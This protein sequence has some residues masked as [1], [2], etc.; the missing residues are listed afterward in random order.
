MTLRLRIENVP[1]LASGDPVEQTLNEHGLVIGRAAHADWTLP[2][3][4]NH[5]SS[6]HAEIDFVDGAY[7]LT[8]RSTNGTFINGSAQRLTAPYP[9]KNGDLITIGQYEIRAEL[10]GARP[11]TAAPGMAG[12][13]MG[14]GLDWLSAAGSGSSAAIDTNRFGREPA[15]PLFQ[16]GADPLM[17]AFQMPGASGP[18]ADPFGIAAPAP[19]G[20]PFGFGG[21]PAAPPPPPAADPF[22]INAPAAPSPAANP[23]G[24]AP[25]A[26]PASSPFGVAPPASDPFG[27]GAPAPPPNTA[28]TTAPTTAPADDPWAKLHAFDTIDFGVAPTAPPPTPPPAAPAAAPATPAGVAATPRATADG[29]FDAF[30]AAAGLK[31]KDIGDLSPAAVLDAAG[32]LLR[33]TADG[34]IRLLDARTRIRHQFGVGANVTTFQRAGNNPLKWT[35]SP[36]QAL[37]QLVGEPDAGFLPGPQAVQGAF[38]DL[39]AHEVAMIAAM[40]DA[41]AAT[42]ERFSPDAIRAR[43][44]AKAGL[45][46]GSREAALWKAFEAEYKVLATESEAA[47]LDLFARNFKKAYERNIAKVDGAPR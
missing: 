28:P 37:R 40:Q 38:E 11:T 18:N 39:Q 25:A 17:H 1:S 34:L 8:D 27:I 9:L 35:R 23:F 30:L 44:N 2:D 15:K 31:P 43:V 14:G 32:R 10:S 21:T 19:A 22:G 4:R 7:V 6:L 5:V 33:Q 26:T 45:L 36:E 3:A 47:Y 16:S 41:M 20:N 42:V 13:G 46:P 12:A 29:A 24:V